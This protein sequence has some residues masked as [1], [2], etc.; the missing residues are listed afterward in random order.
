M[1]GDAEPGETVD[2]DYGHSID[3]SNPSKDMDV[4]CRA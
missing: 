4:C 1:V 3:G 2:P